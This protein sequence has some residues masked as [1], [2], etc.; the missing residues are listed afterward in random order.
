MT[1]YIEVRAAEGGDD[2]KGLVREMVAIYAKAAARQ[3]FS[4]EIVDD[5]PSQVTL[6]FED[7]KAEKLFKNESGGH[8]FQH[9]SPTDK[10]NRIHT[11]TITVAVLG[12]PTEAPKVREEDLQETLYRKAA[13][14]GGQNNNKTA[15]AVRLTH[16][17]TGVRV[18]CCTERSQKSN[19]ETAR[20]LM[21][22]RVYEAT[23]GVANAER[24]ENRKQQVG[25]GQRGDKIRTYREQDNRVTDHRTGKKTT[26]E[27]IRRGELEL[28]E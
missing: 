17:P 22:V 3:G 26:L 28:L 24:A 4:G 10:N 27:K 19:R 21:R 8:R 23:Q 18:E 16:V 1:L 5:R 14:N 6:E 13:G 9:I 20:A 15:T 11:S 12:A 7:P 25:S 2:A